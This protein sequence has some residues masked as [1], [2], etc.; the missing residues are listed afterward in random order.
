MKRSRQVDLVKM[1]GALYCI[2]PRFLSTFAK[3]F[4]SQLMINSS[5]PVDTPVVRSGQWLLT[6]M[7]GQR[8]HGDHP[9]GV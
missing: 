3:G 4:R 6:G 1:S 7:L 9:L 8:C 5:K 2:D